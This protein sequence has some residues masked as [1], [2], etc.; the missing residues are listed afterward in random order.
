MTSILAGAR[1][2]TPLVVTD[3]RSGS[4]LERVTLA[5]GRVVVVK[6]V[7]PAWDWIMRG[8]GD[9]GRIAVLWSSGLLARVPAV[10]DHGVL[11][12]EADGDAWLVIMR[13]LSADFVPEDARLSRAQSRQ[14]LDA[15]AALHAVFWGA[16]HEPRLCTLT[17]RYTL[18]APPNA[19]RERARGNQFAVTILRGWE[20]LAELL[21]ADVGE[22]VLALAERPEPL[23][24]A[25]ARH[26]AT[27]IH[28]DLKLGN[29]GLP[30]PTSKGGGPEPRAGWTEERPPAKRPPTVTAQSDEGSQRTGRRRATDRLNRIVLVDWGTQTGWAPPAV[31]W[32]WYLA[33]NGSRID[34]SHEQVLDDAR[35]AAG[36]HHDQAALDLG[37][38]GGLLQLGWD[39]AIHATEHPDPAIRAREAADLAWWVARSRAGLELLPG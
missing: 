7:A 5:D 13:D 18:L 2:R 1:A 4:A 10:L 12:V 37:L 27:L 29:I 22:A 38:L 21:P 14:I 25:L 3:G 11:A 30:P 6:R 31:E 26:P 17:D 36:E 9:P 28:G 34:A 23:A 20:R 15:A 24:A 33:V 19:E 16:P 35:A 39:K 32:A 8:T